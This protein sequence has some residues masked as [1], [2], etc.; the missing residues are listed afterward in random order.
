[1]YGYRKRVIRPPSMSDVQLRDQ[2]PAGVHGRGQR[3]SCR[4]W[5][6]RAWLGAHRATIG[7]AAPPD[8]ALSA[9]GRCPIG[10]RLR[11]HDS[12]ARARLGRL[13][14]SPKPVHQG[15]SGTLDDG[16]LVMP[17]AP[18]RSVMTQHSDQVPRP[19]KLWLGRALARLRTQRAVRVL[20]LPVAVA[21][22]GAFLLPGTG[23]SAL[24]VTTAAPS[25]DAY[26]SSDAQ[27]TNFGSSTQLRVASS[28]TRPAT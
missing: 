12:S 16:T 4:I 27:N 25:A 9:G 5:P 28:P 14:N 1:M 2:L 8:D 22:T 17:L 11:S 7:V 23:Q 6:E 10:A 13:W 15:L 18:P 3:R 24:V 20:I 21:A 19:A 26:V